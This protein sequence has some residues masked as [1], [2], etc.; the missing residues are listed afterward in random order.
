MTN[1]AGQINALTNSSTG[2]PP[3]V[4]AKNALPPSS[5]TMGGALIL[6]AT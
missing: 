5:I 6:I 3:V 2:N 1:N 4:L